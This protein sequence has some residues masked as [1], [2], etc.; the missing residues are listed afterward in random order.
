MMLGSAQ[1]GPTLPPSWAGPCGG[2][3]KA[4]SWIPTG[5][6]G[7]EVA[8]PCEVEGKAQDLQDPKP[9][10]LGS[11]HMVWRVQQL[12]CMPASLPEAAGQEA[13][14]VVW[15]GVQV[16]CLS[17]LSTPTSLPSGV[18]AVILTIPPYSQP[19][20]AVRLCHHSLEDRLSLESR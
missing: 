20:Q 8:G 10:N 15:I 14:E 6:S 11:R 5:V 1:P 17:A 4:P 9:S 2:D 13:G 7:E 18:T 19:M 16:P 12:W 3:L